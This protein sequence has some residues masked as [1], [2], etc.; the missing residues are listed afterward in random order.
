MFLI[1]GKE[2]KWIVRIPLIQLVIFNNMKSDH[3]RA[4]WKISAKPGLW[5]DDS[6]EPTIFGWWN[7][8]LLHL[9]WRRYWWAWTNAGGDGGK[10]RLFRVT[11]GWLVASRRSSVPRHDATCRPPPAWTQKYTKIH[12]YSQ[13]TH[14]HLAIDFSCG[15]WNGSWWSFRQHMK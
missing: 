1:I 13:N 7:H 14:N 10:S 5:N 9:C 3:S 2:T 6:N 12:I 15:Y 8:S 4:T 11:R